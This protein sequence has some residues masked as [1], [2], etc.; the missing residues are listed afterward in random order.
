MVYLGAFL[1]QKLRGCRQLYSPAPEKCLNVIGLT[2][3]D[4]DKS[5][6]DALPLL[7]ALTAHVLRPVL[8][9][10]PECSS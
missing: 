7:L 1:I 8:R 6:C 10:D 3:L 9:V 4:A 5:F 2:F